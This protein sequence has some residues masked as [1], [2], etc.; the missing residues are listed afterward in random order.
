M[1][2]G[3]FAKVLTSVRG[4]QDATTRAKSVAGLETFI[5]PRFTFGDHP[6]GD[7]ART[8]MFPS[9]TQSHGRRVAA[10]F[11]RSPKAP[12][13][14]TSAR[15]NPRIDDRARKIRDFPAILKGRGGDRAFGLLGFWREA[16]IGAGGVAFLFMQNTPE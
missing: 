9:Q 5:P 6:T 8:A 10:A 11:G 15:G 12:L 14:D 16:I 2:R 1:V 13:F 7:G 3:T 4:N